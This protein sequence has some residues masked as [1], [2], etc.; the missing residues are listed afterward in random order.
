MQL[1]KIYFALVKHR[2]INKESPSLFERLIN[3]CRESHLKGVVFL[4]YP[5]SYKRLLKDLVKSLKKH[6]KNL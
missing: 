1:E 3:T 5:R 4:Q 6:L 2:N